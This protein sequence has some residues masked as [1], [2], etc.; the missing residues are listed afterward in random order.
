[1]V[2]VTGSATVPADDARRASHRCA[3]PPDYF[4]G[5]R[6]LSS[7]AFTVLKRKFSFSLRSIAGLASEERSGPVSGDPFGRLIMIS[8]T[9][10]IRPINSVVSAWD[11]RK[12]SERFALAR[13][14]NIPSWHGTVSRRRA[15]AWQIHPDGAQSRLLQGQPE[16]D[17][18]PGFAAGLAQRRDRI[19]EPQAL[20][21]LGI[22][23][24]VAVG[25]I[26]GP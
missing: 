21:G 17:A 13:A 14:E 5:L 18:F 15:C 7:A 2:P 20:A 12:L 9:S 3:P 19:F 24:R 26:G 4:R 23:P 11:V 25:T 6:A 22:E 10:M 8:C 16:A 1:M